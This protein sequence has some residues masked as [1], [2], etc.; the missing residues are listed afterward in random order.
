[1]NSLFLLLFFFYQPNCNIQ[2]FCGLRNICIDGNGGTIIE[3]RLTLKN[4]SSCVFSTNFYY[5]NSITVSRIH[6]GVWREEKD[7]IRLAR[8]KEISVES[9]RD[10]TDSHIDDPKWYIDF[11][12][13]E[14]KLFAQKLTLVRKAR[15]KNV[16]KQSGD[17]C[18]LP[19]LYLYKDQSAN[20]Y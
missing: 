20:Y 3:C 13:R 19:E 16:L 14:T 9:W 8:L 2:N 5:Y 4:D 6:E 7:T 11:G 17:N 12:L 15:E 10:S 18:R 1:M